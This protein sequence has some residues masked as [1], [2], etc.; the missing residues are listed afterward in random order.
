MPWPTALTQQFKVMC[1]A[2]LSI[3]LEKEAIYFDICATI[4]SEIIIMFIMHSGLPGV[5]VVFI[6]FVAFNCASIISCEGWNE[7]NLGK[8][9]NMLALLIRNTIDHQLDMICARK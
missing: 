9:I 1:E 2:V 5:A 7:L 4:I 8:K 6:F 3:T